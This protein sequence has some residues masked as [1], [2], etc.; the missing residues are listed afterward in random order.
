M[1]PV[2]ASYSAK[3]NRY[4]PTSMTFNF[5]PYNRVKLEMKNENE[6]GAVGLGG[7]T[8]RNT[9]PSTGQDAF[10]ISRIGSDGGVAIGVVGSFSMFCLYRVTGGEVTSEVASKLTE[11]SNPHG[12]QMV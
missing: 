4:D 12:R 1:F 2:A 3:G 11:H 8:R 7:E 6:E 10:F 5:N 9:R